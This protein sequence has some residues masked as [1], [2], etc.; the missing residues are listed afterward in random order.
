[1]NKVF[2]EN[3]KINAQYI[4]FIKATTDKTTNTLRYMSDVLR[5]WNKHLKNKNY[6]ET[7]EQNVIEYLSKYSE[8]NYNPRLSI[9]RNFYRWY[10]KLEENELPIFLKRLKLKSITKIRRRNKM[11]YREKLI[12]EEEYQTLLDNCTKYKH[13][14]IIETLFLFGIRNSELRSMKI[15]GVEYT[16]QGNTKIIVY[17]SKTKPRT[18][19]YDGRAEYLLTWVNNYHPHRNKENAKEH[20]VFNSMLEKPYLTQGI[21]AIL[22]RACKRAGLRRIVPHDFRHTCISYHRKNGTPQ[23]HIEENFGLIEGSKM[24]EVYDHNDSKDYEEWLYQRKQEIKPTF[25]V[26]KKREE[27]HE[28]EIKQLQEE[29]KQI[30]EQLKKFENYVSKLLSERES[31]NPK[32]FR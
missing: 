3:K 16:E 25:V 8:Q 19:I 27:K 32:D 7:T 13:K 30:Q 14:A 31:D 21:D 5:S 10:L 23:T 24:M 17:E 2:E 6:K 15:K 1:M 20:F 22:R 12:T 29:N 26:L 28:K 11:K 4:Q 18:V 9:L